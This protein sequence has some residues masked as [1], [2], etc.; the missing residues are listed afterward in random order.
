MCARIRIAGARTRK[1]K[2]WWHISRTITAVWMRHLRKSKF[3]YL[4][5]NAKSEVQSNLR[6]SFI[7]SQILAKSRVSAINI[8]GFFFPA[9]RVEQ[10]HFSHLTTCLTTCGDFCTISRYKK[11]KICTFVFTQRCKFYYSTNWNL[12][13]C[14]LLTIIY[15]LSVS[16]TFTTDISVLPIIDNMLSR[17]SG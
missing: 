1:S 4:L 12:F 3:Y 17:V 16:I 8:M 9:S 15:A 13:Y 6:F 5:Y 11:C 2:I 14:F 7:S 10:A